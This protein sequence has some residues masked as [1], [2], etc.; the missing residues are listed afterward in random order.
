[1]TSPPPI[2]ARSQG[3]EVS[4]EGAS[5]SSGIGGHELVDTTASGP[6]H[7]HA[8]TPPQA[9]QEYHPNVDAFDDM[10]DPRLVGRVRHALP[11]GELHIELRD[12]R[13]ATVRGAEPLAVGTVVL[14][15]SDSNYIEAAPSELWPEELLIGVVRLKRDDVT[16]LDTGGRP[17]R[18]PTSDVSYSEGNTVEATLAHG[19]SRVLSTDPIRYIDLSTIDASVVEQFKQRGGGVR[20]TYDD[21]GG[22]AEIVERARELIELPL[23]YGEQLAEIGARPIKGVLFTGPPGTGKTMLARIIAGSAGATFYSISGP[24]IFSKWYGES[25]KVLR[26]VFKDARKEKRAIIFFDE[27]DAVAGQRADDSH[28]ASRRVVAQ[29]LALMDG[30]KADE[31]VIVIAATNRPQDIDA[32]L[33]RPGRFDWEIEFP[34][35]SLSDRFLILKA[36][37]KPLRASGPLPHDWAA[38][39]TEGWSAAELSAIWSEAALLAVKDQR[40][41]IVAE[42]YVG[43]LEHVSRHRLSQAHTKRTEPAQ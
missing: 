36:S 42:D 8:G 22:M 38:D 40:T 27:I 4:E 5:P 25:E 34:L 43:G 29:L 31:H 11:N 33:R 35:P 1:M 39:Q 7:R 12:G 30:F 6:L 21:F 24:E 10:T 41:S 28:E 32:A 17:L 13:F 15:D 23:K 16:I 37:S 14:I 18:I 26:E 19:V 20:E 9:A 3:M 2:I